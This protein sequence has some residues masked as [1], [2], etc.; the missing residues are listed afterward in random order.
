MQPHTNKDYAITSQNIH[1]IK[2]EIL[3]RAVNI[4]MNDEGGEQYRSFGYL[5]L[6][7]SDPLDLATLSQSEL[8]VFLI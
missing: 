3:Y 6:V 2:P 4:I 7:V 5:S 1:K 8:F